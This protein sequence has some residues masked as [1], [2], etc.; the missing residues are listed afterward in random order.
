MVPCYLFFSLSSH[1]LA[2]G[3]VVGGTRQ[4]RATRAPVFLLEDQK[5]EPQGTRIYQ[6]RSGEG[7]TLESNPVKIF[8][9]SQVHP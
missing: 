5:G 7:E 9:N 3:T 8:M 1:C 2:A 4:S 6:G